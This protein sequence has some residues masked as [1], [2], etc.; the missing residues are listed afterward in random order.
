MYAWIGVIMILRIFFTHINYV[1]DNIFQSYILLVEVNFV[2]RVYGDFYRHN[3]SLV[4]F[5]FDCA[6]IFFKLWKQRK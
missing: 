6:L 5:N 1:T 3:V 2:M 4:L